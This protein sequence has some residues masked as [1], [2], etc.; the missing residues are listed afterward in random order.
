LEENLLFDF[1]DGSNYRIFQ[2]F[3]SKSV[4]LTNKEEFRKITQERSAAPAYRLFADGKAVADILTR[5]G[6]EPKVC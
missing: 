4:A 5:H 2:P 3:V 6:N 1:M